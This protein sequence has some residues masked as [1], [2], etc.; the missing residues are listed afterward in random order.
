MLGLSIF[1]DGL[2]LQSQVGST[3]SS[4]SRTHWFV[5]PRTRRILDSLEGPTTRHIRVFPVLTVGGMGARVLVSGWEQARKTILLTIP[6]RNITKTKF[7]QHGWVSGH[8][9]LV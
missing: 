8:F 9:M 6:T 1:A 3:G 2:L 4:R 7:L 5:Y